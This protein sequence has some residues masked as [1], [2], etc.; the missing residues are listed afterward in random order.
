MVS[1]LWKEELTGTPI[2]PWEYKEE[3]RRKK[4]Q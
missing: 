3:V 1:A 2:E 4:I